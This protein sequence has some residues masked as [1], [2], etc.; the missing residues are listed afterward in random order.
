VLQRKHDTSS[1]AVSPH[2]IPFLG[3]SLIT[4]E[5]MG[6]LFLQI[7]ILN[8]ITRREVLGR[9]YAYFSTDLQVRKVVSGAE[10]TEFETGLNPLPFRSFLVFTKSAGK[11]HAFYA[12]IKIL[13]MASTDPQSTF[14]F[15][16]IL[17]K[18]V[19]AR[20]LCMTSY[21]WN[22]IHTNKQVATVHTELSVFCLC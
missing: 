20:M 21:Y 19:H 11:F 18:R 5:P 6:G 4:A 14:T 22:T 2:A 3:L 10:G 15:I 12:I 1:G 16:I 17:C 7:S 8:F 9:G 13:R